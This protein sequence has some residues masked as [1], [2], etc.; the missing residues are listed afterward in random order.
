MS[1]SLGNVIDPLALAERYGVDLRQAN[2]AEIAR[3]TAEGIA[4]LQGSVFRLSPTGYL[5]ADEISGAFLARA[6]GA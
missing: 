6:A 4:T 2:A 3:L 5:L 1:K